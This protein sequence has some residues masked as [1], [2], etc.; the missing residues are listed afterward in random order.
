MRRCKP[1][2]CAYILW[3][4]QFNEVMAAM[5]ASELRTAGWRTWLVGLH[6][7][8]HVGRFGVTL[9]ADLSLGEALR[10]RER[11]VCL[12]APCALEAVNNDPDPRLGELLHKARAQQAVFL[13]EPEL[14]AAPALEHAHFVEGRWLA[15]AE[16]TQ[17]AIAVQALLQE[18]SVQLHR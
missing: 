12:V 15:Q 7:A 2:G 9:V 8:E 1:N 11:M 6:G 3:G 17:L 5:A 14:P 13:L 10:A 4:D 16:P 18:L